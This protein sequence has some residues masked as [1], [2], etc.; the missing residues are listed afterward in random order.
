MSKSNPTFQ[1]WDMFIDATQLFLNSMR[2]NRVGNWG[3]HLHCVL[4]KLKYYKGAN[5]PNYTRWSPA[6]L[7][8]MILLPASATEAF[9]KGEFTVRHIKGS[10]NAVPTHT[11]TEHHVKEMKGPGGVKNVTRNEPALMRWSLIRHV[12]GKYSAQLTK[13]IHSVDKK[14]RKHPEEKA[15]LKR[16]EQDIN[17]FLSHVH[18]NMINPFTKDSE[19]N[20]VLVNI[21]SGVHANFSV[22]NSLLNC[23]KRGVAAEWVP[24]TG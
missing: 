4:S 15:T 6:Y 1:I 23:I 18:S 17:Q 19:H 10:F 11:S 13:Q 7:L 20:E 16:D 3:L 24:S 9:E 2:A 12:T 14:E 8:D 5:K 21:S 22:Q